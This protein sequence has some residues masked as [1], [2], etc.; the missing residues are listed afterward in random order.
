M[1]VCNPS[2][3][4]RFYC[5]VFYSFQLPG[6]HF[7][8]LTYLVIGDTRINLGGLY[9]CMS[10]HFRYRFNGYAFGQR[11]CRG[12]GVPGYVEYKVKSNS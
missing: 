11:G 12:E 2:R 7:H 10:Q 8:I 9:V 1:A 4:H 5:D 6:K 3:C